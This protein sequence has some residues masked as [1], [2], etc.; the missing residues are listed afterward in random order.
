MYFL[1]SCIS[2]FVLFLSLSLVP[3]FMSMPQP[4]TRVDSKNADDGDGGTIELPAPVQDSRIVSFLNSG[5]RISGKQNSCKG[6][7]E[8]QNSSRE[9]ASDTLLPMVI[10][11]NA[12]RY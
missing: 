8:K 10:E 2:Y 4:V 11:A 9:G 6:V 1:A 7:S 12:G 3:D 5:K